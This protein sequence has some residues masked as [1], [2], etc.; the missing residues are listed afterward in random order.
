LNFGD[1]EIFKWLIMSMRQQEVNPME[2]KN[3]VRFAPVQRKSNIRSREIC[4][5]LTSLFSGSLSNKPV[6]AKE[7][8]KVRIERSQK[9]S[10]LEKQVCIEVQ[11]SLYG[12]TLKI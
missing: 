2:E 4:K 9:Q 7:T 10:M 1:W 3:L 6:D 5:I 8:T 12:L 11:K